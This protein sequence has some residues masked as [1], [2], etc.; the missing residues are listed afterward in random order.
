MLFKITNQSLIQGSDEEPISMVEQK[1]SKLLF[2]SE[3]SD[4]CFLVGDRAEKIYAHRLLLVTKSEVFKSMFYGKLKE[5]NYEIKVPDI[6][7][8]GFRNMLK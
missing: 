5:T 7:P 4:V 2:D 6:S 8:V 3:F 1:I